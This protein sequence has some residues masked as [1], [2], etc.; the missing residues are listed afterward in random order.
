MSLTIREAIDRRARLAPESVF[1][2]APQREPLSSSRL[3]S[4]V[5]SIAER[6]G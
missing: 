2:C 3:A 5:A 6:L 1:L 4:F